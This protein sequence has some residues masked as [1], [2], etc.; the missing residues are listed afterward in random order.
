MNEA[1]FE[2]RDVDYSYGGKFPALRG[3]NFCVRRGERVVLV[4]A[5]GSGKS[6]LLHLCDGLIFPD[7]GSLKA[8]GSDLSE[9]AFQEEAFSLAFR[10]QVGFV[11]QN[12]DVQLFCPTVQEDILFGPAQLGLDSTE[13]RKRMEELV[14]FLEIAPLLGRAP[15][16][17][18]IGEKRKV[19]I[20]SVFVMNPQVLILDEPTAGLDPLTTR[21]IV[22]FL[23][24]ESDSGKTILTSTHDLHIV[25]EI[26]DIV[27]VFGRDKKIV[28][29]GPA[30]AILK[31]ARLLEEN[32]LVHIH[33]HRHDKTVHAHPHQHLD[34][35]H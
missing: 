14:A 5:N 23:I 9:G 26:A 12:P 30:D 16:Q 3:I 33:R 4:G 25:E 27:H 32:N 10:K 17:L 29:S 2:L 34:H 24:H 7:K 22:D 13:T 8:F 6:T 15:H 31:D 19:V 20:A 28:S 18:S 21:H 1:V 11:F 35:H